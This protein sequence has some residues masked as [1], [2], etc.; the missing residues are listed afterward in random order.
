MK[1]INVYFVN[2]E[3]NEDKNA[4]EV[5][6]QNAIDIMMGNVNLDVNMLESIIIKLI[7]MLMKKMQN[8]KKK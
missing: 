3:I 6:F 2:N 8:K 7:L 5:K 4:Y 1:D